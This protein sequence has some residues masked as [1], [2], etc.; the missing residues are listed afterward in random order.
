MILTTILLLLIF[1]ILLIL[2]VISLSYNYQFVIKYQEFISTEIFLGNKLINFR[3]KKSKN[4]QKNFIKILNYKKEIKKENKNKDKNQEKIQKKIEK[5]KK[6]KDENDNK[7]KFSL[8]NKKN[9]VHILK[10]ILKIYKEIKPDLIKIDLNISLSDP[11]YNGLIMAN[12]YSIKNAY[13]N[14]PVSVSTYWDQEVV[15]GKAEIKGQIKPILILFLIL[16]FIFSP[17]TLK[18]IWQYRKD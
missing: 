7:F 6:D 5:A 10:F 15:E 2:F 18:I 9:L 11:Y 16:K 14:F 8:I 1:I 4:T 13:P 17:Q 3:Y 12:Y